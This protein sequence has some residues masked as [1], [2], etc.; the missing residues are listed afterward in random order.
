MHAQR[1]HTFKNALETTQPDLACIQEVRVQ[2]LEFPG[3]HKE[4]SANG[5]VYTW[6]KHSVLYERDSRMEASLPCDSVVV[7]LQA[8]S[9][10]LTL[11]NIYVNPSDD[12]SSNQMQRILRIIDNDQIIALGDFNAPGITCFNSSG[13]VSA[14]GKILDEYLQASENLGIFTEE[15]ITFVR[16]SYEARLDIGFSSHVVAQHILSESFPDLFSDH[17][18]L[19]HS[20]AIPIM[21]TKEIG[22]PCYRISTDWKALASYLNSFENN[23]DIPHLSFDE[24]LLQIQNISEKFQIPLDTS[25]ITSWWN[26]ECKV[27]IRERNKAWR[28]WK[29]NVELETSKEKKAIFLAK[30]RNARKTIRQAKKQWKLLI[31]SQVNGSKAQWLAISALCGGRRARHNER[32]VYR[33]PWKSQQLAETQCQQFETLQKRENLPSKSHSAIPEP[34]QVSRSGKSLERFP[35]AK[36]KV[37]QAL[38]VSPLSCYRSYGSMATGRKFWSL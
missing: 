19:L 7:R 29:N 16:D 22:P 8:G 14:R 2:A 27:A 1:Y 5:L 20:F 26:E 21:K 28:K 17:C 3:Y 38:I 34:L 30:K 9:G 24:A 10:S 13:S 15:E 37:H 12:I 11:A 25:K 33:A 32:T 23:S 36:K 35:T 18:A 4:A 6:I 31:L